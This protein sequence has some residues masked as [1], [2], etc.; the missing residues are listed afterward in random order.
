MQKGDKMNKKEKETM[1]KALC[2]VKEKGKVSEYG[3]SKE[4]KVKEGGSHKTNT[5]T[6][7]RLFKRNELSG[8]FTTSVE[9][10]KHKMNYHEITP[11]GMLWLFKEG[12]ISFQELIEY[13]QKSDFLGLGEEN[14]PIDFSLSFW[15]LYRTGDH[16]QF[17]FEE[18]IRKKLSIFDLE[19]TKLEEDELRYVFLYTILHLVPGIRIDKNEA[20]NQRFYRHRKKEQEKMLK[21]LITFKEKVGSFVEYILEGWE[22]L[23]KSL[24]ASP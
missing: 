21:D 11:Q 6:L 13:L 18:K 19:S 15:K 4:L 20:V 12:V 2:V 9:T 1:K 23:F 17:Y 3:I 8:L 24:S 16:G 7:Q 14:F 5:S 10:H 22:G